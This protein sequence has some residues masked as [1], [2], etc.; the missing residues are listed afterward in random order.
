MAMAATPEG[1]EAKVRS[2]AEDVVSRIG[3]ELVD[4][5]YRREP[6]GW[7]LRLF[8]DKDGGVGLDDCE[9]VSQ[10]FG[11]VLEVEDPIPNQFNLEVSSPG[12]DRRLKTEN[13]FR[14]AEGKRIRLV[15]RTPISGQRNFNGRL[16]SAEPA[17]E[18]APGQ[19]ALRIV[20]DD[21][22]ESVVP[23]GE[24]DRARLVYEWPQSPA[25]AGQK[26]KRRKS[27]RSR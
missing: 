1:I 27:G 2:L 25:R 10:E 9:R 16:I 6:V 26:K 11:T 15:A 17:G 13:D 20:A 3:Y 12:L 23:S 4:L 14:M 7:V 5:E 18:D 8:I 19:L 21:G 24:V 22:T